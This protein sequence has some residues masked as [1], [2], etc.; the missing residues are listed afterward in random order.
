[1]GELRFA[2]PIKP[3]KTYYNRDATV[4]YSSYVGEKFL[5]RDMLIS[6]FYSRWIFG[7]FFLFFFKKKKERTAA[8]PQQTFGGNTSSEP[9][10]SWLNGKKLNPLGHIKAF[11]PGQEDCLTLDVR[12]INFDLDAILISF[13]FP[14]FFFCRS[15]G[16]Q[17]QQTLLVSQ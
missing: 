4:G 3:T 2:N 6:L 9:Y 12:T 13:V 16:Q 17:A 5:Q 1:V 14:S 8:C 10:Q 7:F 11:G 15:L